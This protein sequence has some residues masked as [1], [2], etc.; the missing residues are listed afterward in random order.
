MS[1]K[2]MMA[3]IKKNQAR[4]KMR[5]AVDW[6]YAQL[7]ELSDYL[8]MGMDNGLREKCLHAIKLLVA[9]AKKKDKAW[10]E[11]WYVVGI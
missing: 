11:P 8:E 1:K 7:R 4:E 6:V 2:E 3:K 9:W 5:H 10:R